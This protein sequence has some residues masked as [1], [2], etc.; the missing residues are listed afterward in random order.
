MARRIISDLNASVWGFVAFTGISFGAGG[1]LVK[2]L[3]NDGIDAFTV[4]WVP[5]L[6]GALLH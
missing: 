4:T 1:L 3:T 5:F 6:F 2:K